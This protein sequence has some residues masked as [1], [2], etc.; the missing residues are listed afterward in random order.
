[1][2]GELHCDVPCVGIIDGEL[3]RNPDWHEPTGGALA[4]ERCTGGALAGERYEDD[5]EPR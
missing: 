1:M 5:D 2:I 4:G 3:R